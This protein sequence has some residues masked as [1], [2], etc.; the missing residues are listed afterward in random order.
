M[1]IWMKNMSTN[2]LQRI[3]VLQERN[4]DVQRELSE[5]SQKK[6]EKKEKKTRRKLKNA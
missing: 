2:D 4:Y 1:L 5:S 3:F 6:R